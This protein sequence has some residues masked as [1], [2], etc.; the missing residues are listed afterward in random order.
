[1]MFCHRH[2]AK[3]GCF[4]R[5]LMEQ[6]TLIHV[7]TYLRRWVQKFWTWFRYRLLMSSTF[8]WI[9]L[10]KSSSWSKESTKATR[11]NSPLIAK[12]GPKGVTRLVGFSIP[13]SRVLVKSNPIINNL[14]AHP[15]WLT[16]SRF[17]ESTWP[18]EDVAYQAHEFILPQSCLSQLTDTK[19]I[20]FPAEEIEFCRV[21]EGTSCDFNYSFVIKTQELKSRK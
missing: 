4:L 5:F 12:C 8:Q 6:F 21:S 9:G 13:S 1:M 14:N 20:N 10:K 17:K 15:R 7:S 11:E 19:F 3:I 18:G 2:F 16:A